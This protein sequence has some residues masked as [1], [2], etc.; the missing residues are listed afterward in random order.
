MP[1]KAGD[2]GTLTADLGKGN[3]QVIYTARDDCDNATMDTLHFSVLD[4]SPPDLICPP[5]QPTLVLNEQGERT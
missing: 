5:L 1:I 4:C 3:Y 2:S